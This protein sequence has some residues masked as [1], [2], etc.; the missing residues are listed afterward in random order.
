MALKKKMRITVEYL[1]KVEHC[2]SYEIAMR[3]FNELTKD[4]PCT[5][6]VIVRINGEVVA[7]CAPL[8]INGI[9]TDL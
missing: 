3:R 1:G 5:L 2:G 9:P 8:V 7:E 4:K 6:H